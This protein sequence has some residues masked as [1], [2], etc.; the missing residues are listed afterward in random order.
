MP[1]PDTSDTEKMALIGRMTVLRR[2]RRQVAEKLRDKV[3]SMLNS[4]EDPKQSW[5][6]SGVVELV[7]EIQALSEA[8]ADLG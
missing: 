4:F 7:N 6:V 5:D 1:I 8:L 3:V 2:A